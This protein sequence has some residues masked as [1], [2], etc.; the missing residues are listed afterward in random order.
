VNNM[1]HFLQISDL[2][3]VEINALL[4]R[5]L[6]FKKTHT[7]PDYSQYVTANLF[8]EN[9]TRTRVSFELA[10][11]RLGMHSVNFDLISSS[12]SKGETIEDTIHNLAAMGISI[13]VIRH[14]QD[15]LQ[16]SL[17]Q[18][19][20]NIHII[21][22]GDGKHA[23]PSQAMLDLMTI[24]EKKPDLKQL[25]V[26]IVGDILHSRV[27]NSLQ[28][29]FSKVEIGELVM[30]GPEAWHPTTVHYGR[31]TN[32]LADGLKDADVIIGLRVQR[33]RIAQSESM[34]LQ[35]FRQ[36]Y[37]LTKQ[38]LTYAKPNAI[39]MHPG[40]INRGIEIDSDVA[41]GPQSYI[42]EQ[43]KNGV[44]MRMAILEAAIKSSS[45]D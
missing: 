33:E 43:V 14:S 42:L 8:Y 4:Q 19:I 29:I 44:Y 24:I 18:R 2:S 40:P 23:H 38:A 37:A 3:H 16:Q 12:E 41:D 17:A 13:F 31:V 15:G 34:D 26:A 1:Q 5:A 25:K 22:A 7:Y 21:N 36:H 11:Q 28:V 6:H 45:L 10:A 30:V 32:S 9:S 39:I 27:A 35:A 20:H